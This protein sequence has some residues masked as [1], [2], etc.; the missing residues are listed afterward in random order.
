MDSHLELVYRRLLLP[1]VVDT[2]ITVPRKYKEVNYLEIDKINHL[3]INYKERFF[4]YRA[5]ACLVPVNNDF[6]NSISYDEV[7][8]HRLWL[9]GFIYSE[10]RYRFSEECLFFIKRHQHDCQCVCNIKIKFDRPKTVEE[11][12]PEIK[13]RFQM[14]DLD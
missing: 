1:T 4:D 6:A 7:L 14:M 12:V 10:K 11:K 3:R 9:K 5:I 13:N 2:W 8:P